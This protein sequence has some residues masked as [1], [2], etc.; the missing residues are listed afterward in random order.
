MKPNTKKLETRLSKEFS[1]EFF[2]NIPSTV[3]LI[4]KFK[5]EERLIN[6]KLRI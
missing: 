1:I 3:S 4:D 6:E 2:D 5:Q